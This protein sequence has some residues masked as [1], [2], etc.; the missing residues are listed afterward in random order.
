M[1]LGNAQ[2]DLI[3]SIRA[4]TEEC[5]QSAVDQDGVRAMI[6]GALAG[7]QAPEAVIDAKH[8][9]ATRREAAI[10]V[11]R[12]PHEAQHGHDLHAERR[13]E[14]GRH[15]GPHAV[16]ARGDGQLRSP[17]PRQNEG[18]QAGAHRVAHDQGA[19]HDGATHNDAE[20]H[21]GV[22]ASMEARA[23]PCQP[24]NGHAL[25]LPREAPAPGTA[26]AEGSTGARRP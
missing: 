4:Q 12:V 26:V 7:V 1:N 23:T 3:V 19:G 18:P 13:L 2:N 11:G 24:A 20:H 9:H 21:G 15:L 25:T 6:D 10:A 22:V 16:L 8:L 17:Q 14:R 5:G